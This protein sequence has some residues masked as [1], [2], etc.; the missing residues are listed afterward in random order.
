LQ[1][2]DEAGSFVVQCRNLKDLAILPD[3]FIA[4]NRQN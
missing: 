4:C 1:E 3:A 2:I